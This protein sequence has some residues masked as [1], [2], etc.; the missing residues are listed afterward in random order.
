ML[1]EM[2]KI[3]DEL[4]RKVSEIRH[5]QMELNKKENSE[6]N[7]ATERLKRT[8]ATLEQENIDLKVKKFL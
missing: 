6:A 8:V 5:L 4:S 3:R 2:N 1:T 7:D